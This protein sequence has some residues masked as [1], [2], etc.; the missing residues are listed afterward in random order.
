MRSVKPQH[1][2]ETLA[3]LDAVIEQITVDAAGDDE[4]LWAFRHALEE[5]IVVP[6]DAFVVGEPVSVIGFDYDGNVPWTDGQV[7]S[8]GWCRI[9]RCGS[10]CGA[11]PT[12]RG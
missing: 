12:H 8:W 5:H 3:A 6:C 7:P 2:R 1:E 10:G 11:F 4:K 9:H